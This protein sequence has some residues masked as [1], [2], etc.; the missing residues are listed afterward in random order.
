[1]HTKAVSAQA[2]VGQN[3]LLP[4]GSTVKLSTTDLDNLMQALDI[5]VI[6]L[7]EILVPHGHRVE[8]GTIDA[9][10][11]HYNLS[12]VGRISING[13]P[14]MPLSPHLLIIVPPN[15]PFTIEVD[16]G[17]GPP[18]LISK[19]CW[20]R[21][22]GILRVAV[23]NEQPEIVQICGFF[24]A[25]FGQSVRLF[26][27]LGVPVIEQ[28]EPA[29]KIDL[30]LREA[31]DELMQQEVGVGAMTASLLKQIVV[32]LV[33]RSVKS[34]QRWTERFSIL[35]DRQVTRAFAD[36]VARPG[37]AHSVQ[38]LAH[39]AGLSRSAFM[40]RFSDIFGQS[41]MVIL[42]ALRMRQAAID[43][44]T[45]TMS[46]DVV[47]HNAGYESRSSFVRAFRKAYGRDP[48]DYRRM[49]RD[50]EARKDI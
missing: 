38:S 8:F 1:M 50:G 29:D 31:M 4:T 14:T 13:G 26:G 47:A 40:A 3:M 16:G 17:S 33:R 41:P 46:I 15:T 18:K 44:T 37:A 21:Q 27:E 28:F 10:G 25:S 36:M 42:R 30:K 35:A 48:S 19:E 43:L 39:S 32:S 12:G 45:T 6:A 11:I 9:P 7:T 5:D 2:L 20:T 24:N 23:P 34:S 22:D 49:A